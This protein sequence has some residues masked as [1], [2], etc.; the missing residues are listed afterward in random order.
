M[1]LRPSN[2]VIAL[3]QLCPAEDSGAP[4]NVNRAGSCA[5]VNLVP[6]ACSAA[7]AMAKTKGRGDFSAR[8]YRLGQLA[9]LETCRGAGLRCDLR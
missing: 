5:S 6:E 2:C 7:L 3:E 1:S 9:V 4:L 8:K